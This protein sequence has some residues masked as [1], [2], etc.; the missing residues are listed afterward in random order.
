MKF[1][2][3]MVVMN[4]LLK[5]IVRIIVVM[6]VARLEK[7]TTWQSNHLNLMSVLLLGASGFLKN[8]QTVIIIPIALYVKKHFHQRH[9]VKNGTTVPTADV[10]C[11]VKKMSVSKWAW[12]EECDNIICIGECD[13]CSYAEEDNDGEDQQ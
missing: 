8:I 5:K 12:T 6:A 9:I 13:L 4:V 1:L 7:P 2:K 10:K 11:E 3:Q